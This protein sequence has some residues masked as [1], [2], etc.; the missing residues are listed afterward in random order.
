[1][2]TEQPQQKPEME[3]VVALAPPQP[4]PA[5]SRYCHQ[6]RQKRTDLAP[7]CKRIMEN[8]KS[9]RIRYCRM[10]FINRYG[11]REMD[12][13][14]QD[15]WNCPKCMGNCN[16]SCCRK[17]NGEIPTGPLVHAARMLGLSSAIE[18]LESPSDLVNTMQ[19]IWVMDRRKGCGY[20]DVT[21]TRFMG[22][23]G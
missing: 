3:V 19:E 7:P 2:E 14:Q 21:T 9:C 10:C 11:Q 6:C 22:L 23:R 8:N 20:P 1:M 5:V 17:N 15:G 18:L 13:A 4:Q 12:A 16:C